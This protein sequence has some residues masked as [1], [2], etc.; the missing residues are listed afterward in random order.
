MYSALMIVTVHKLGVTEIL[1]FF[2]ALFVHP[3]LNDPTCFLLFPLLVL[4]FDL[5]DGSD[6]FL[7]N[8]G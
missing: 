2:Y 5:E 3:Q 6:M 7:R 4:L 1:L 8:I